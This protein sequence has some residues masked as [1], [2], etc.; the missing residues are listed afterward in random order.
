MSL[1]LNLGQDILLLFVPFAPFKVVQCV[2]VVFY[3]KRSLGILNWK[4]WGRGKEFYFSKCQVV[5]FGAATEEKAVST[6]FFPNYSTSCRLNNST[7]KLSSVLSL[8]FLIG[9]SFLEQTIIGEYSIIHLPDNIP[10]MRKYTCLVFLLHNYKSSNFY[11]Y[12]SSVTYLTK[13]AKV[14]FFLKMLVE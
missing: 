12:S 6:G 11:K 4:K 14:P 13:K 1:I 3:R 8:H 10:N 7:S 2:V 5:I 9:V